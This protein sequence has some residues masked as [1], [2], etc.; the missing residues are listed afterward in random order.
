[1]ARQKKLHETLNGMLGRQA[2]MEY[3]LQVNASKEMIT[4]LYK[5]SSAYTQL[6][7]VAGYAA[8]FAIWHSLKDYLTPVSVLWTTEKRSLARG[9]RL[10]Q[11]K[12]IA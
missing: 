5:Q 9:R 8:Y 1:M 3:R 4:H 7:M 12:R 11:Q 6:I 10:Q 2:S